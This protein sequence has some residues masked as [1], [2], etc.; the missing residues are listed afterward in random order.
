M[1]NPLKSL[2]NSQKKKSNNQGEKCAYVSQTWLPSRS[3]REA[4]RVAQAIT[5]NYAGKPTAPHE[6]ALALEFSPT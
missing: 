5:D 6:I 4:L 2:P 3:L 1:E